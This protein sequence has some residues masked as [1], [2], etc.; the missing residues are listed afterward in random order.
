M[1]KLT[2]DKIKWILSVESSQAQQEVH[3][4]AEA[5]KDLAR[6]Q[7]EIQKQMTALAAQGKK[8]SDEYKN[9]SKELKNNKDA[10]DTNKRAQSELLKQVDLTSMSMNELRKRASDLKKQLDNVPRSADPKAWDEQK[11]Q[12]D[13]VYEQ[14]GNLRQGGQSLGQQLGALPGPVGAATRGLQG[15]AQSAKLLLA[16]PIGLFITGLVAAFMALKTAIAGSDS[17][18]TKLDAW[19]KAFGV[20]LDTLK[21]NLTEF[22]AILYKV[23]TFKWGEIGENIDNIKEINGALIENMVAAHDATIAE[24]ALNDAIARNNDI[25]EVNKARIS[26]LRQISRDTTLSYEERKKASTEVMEL[27]KQNYEMAIQNVKGQFD[28]FKGQNKNLM[29]AMRRS[30]KEQFEEMEKYMAMVQ[31]GTELTYQQR[32]ELANLVNDITKSLDEGTEEQKEKFRS[33]VNEMS[34]ITDNHYK[35]SRRD[36]M[37]DSQMEQERQRN[38]VSAAK[39]ALQDA[40]ANAD[41]AQT[42]ETNQLKEQ[43]AQRLISRKEYEKQLEQIAIDGINRKLAISGI[44]AT[45]RTQLEGQLLDIQIKQQADAQKEHEQAEKDKIQMLKNSYDTELKL[46]DKNQ[47]EMRKALLKQQADGLLSEAEV[48]DAIAV[49]EQESAG[50]KLAIN[51]AYQADLMS[52]EIHTLGLKEKYIEEANARIAAAEMEQLKQE[53]ETRK[54]LESAY[55]EY[56]TAAGLNTADD[57]RRIRI[58]A[59]QATYEERMRLLKR[60]HQDTEAL[61]RAH[62]QALARIEDEYN[63]ERMEARRSAGLATLAEIIKLELQGLK[64]QHRKGLITEKEYQQARKQLIGRFSSEIASAMTGMITGAVDAMQQAEIAGVEAKYAAE[65]AAAE[66]N[67]EKIA[68]IENRKEAEK[69]AIQKKYA[70]V[71]FAVKVSEIIAN[72]AVAIM[73]AYAQLGPVAGSIAAGVLA[74]TGAAQVALANAEREKVKNAVP[75][76]GGGG[77]SAVRV[78]SGREDGGYIDVEREQDGRRFRA[79]HEPR[80]RGYVDRPTVIVGEGPAGQSREWVASNAAL[81]N[82]TIAPIISLLDAAQLSGRIRSIDMNAV[83]ARVYQG[84]ESGGFISPAPSGGSAAARTFGRMGSSDRNTVALER[85][86]RALERMSDEGIPATVVYSEL[87]RKQSIINKTKKIASRS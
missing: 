51:A 66:G 48:Q 4:L 76:G 58:A 59:L 18:R 16:N 84:R 73:Q 81:E 35:E 83:M 33:F 27:E 61:E 65:I 82:P 21:R 6:E 39:S 49:L 87:Q 24:D 41:Q 11:A 5:N 64:E 8:S 38:A 36:K 72:T 17:G 86:A 67:Q 68:E 43:L 2:E 12:L 26:E 34:T 47:A 63:I 85:F 80:R 45:Q 37:A 15:M 60:E 70:D 9:L 19:M 23:F 57:E 50:Q 53:V 30:S 52:L 78:A 13:A 22:G 55:L 79:L 7:R 62:Q 44:E 28:V 42:E 46:H 1:A 69:L 71:Q 29:D 54:Q 14:M 40:L 25:T 31:E 75:G 3:R 74:V 77:S 10:I 32:L 56:R 20:A